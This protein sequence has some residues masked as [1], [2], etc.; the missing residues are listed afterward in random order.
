MS[1]L[2]RQF[3]AD[4]LR[5]LQKYPISCSLTG[6]TGLDVGYM[7]FESERGLPFIQMAEAGADED[8]A[9]FYLLWWDQNAN[10][11]YTE[12]VVRIR[13]KTQQLDGTGLWALANFSKYTI[14][15]TTGI[16]GIPESVKP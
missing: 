4:P 12:K 8:R 9:S 13:T 10:I 2:T 6:A 5:F 16:V 11:F 1:N 3:T 7:K 15:N 14:K